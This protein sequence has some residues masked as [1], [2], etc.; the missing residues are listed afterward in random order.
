MSN[1][2]VITLEKYDKVGQRLW[3]DDNIGEA[4]HIHLND[5]RVDM[6]VAEFSA[7]VEKLYDIINELVQVEGFD[8]RKYNPVYLSVML[9]KYLPKLRQVSKDEVMLSDLI[10]YK[11]VIGPF[12][13][14][15]R[16]PDSK[17]VKALNGDSRENDGPCSSHHI[18]QTSAQRLDSVMESIREHG[19]P[20]ND[21]YII[22]YNDNM[23]IR[24]GQHRAAC[25]YKL[26]GDHK[27][28]VLR[29]YFDDMKKRGDANRMLRAN[30]RKALQSAQAML[31]ALSHPHTYTRAARRLWRKLYLTFYKLTNKRYLHLIEMAFPQSHSS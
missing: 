30:A 31:R 3:L 21:Q 14:R 15:V 24:D 20:H 17:C 8:A 7:F 16:L 23:L 6:S 27:V 5:L 1:P 2:G 13:R 12:L 11:P 9:G 25:L 18:G 29:L 22:L 4:V 28:P 19:Y 10:L 26:Y